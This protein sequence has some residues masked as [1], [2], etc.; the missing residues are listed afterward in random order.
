MNSSNTARL[1]DRLRALPV[2]TAAP[3]ALDT[4]T[5]PSRPQQLFVDWL[6]EAIAAQV[7]EAHAMTLST[8]DREGYPNARVLILKDVDQHGWWFATDLLSVKAD[9][10]DANPRAALTFYW[11]EVGRQVRV[12]GRVTR[13]D[14]ET[15]ML[16]F[17]SRS[18]R[19][20]AVVL[21]AE[22]LVRAG[23]PWTRGDLIEAT[24]RL[25]HELREEQAAGPVVPN[26]PW[27][28]HAVSPERV[29][30]WQ[31]DA[32]RLHHRIRYVP[33]DGRWTIVVVP[34]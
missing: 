3:G 23:D 25:E 12:Q 13:A 22:E 2:L 16:D 19:A 29:E 4:A 1:R 9:E 17:A 30:F 14:D 32:G 11:P 24:D 34:H 5:L 21:A 27:V 20:R 15:S 31:A 10:L 6:D 18:P 33:D 26:A 28:A 8:V 7:R